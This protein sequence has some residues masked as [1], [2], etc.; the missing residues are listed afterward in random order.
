MRV[1]ATQALRLLQEGAAAVDV[2]SAAEYAAGHLP[3]ALHLPLEDLEQ[4][5]T[6]LPDLSRPLVLYCTSGIRSARAAAVL[7]AGGWQHIYEL[8]ALR[9]WPYG[10]EHN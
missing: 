8:G 2:R 5:R 3:G 1:N 7:R 10:I 9:S 6:V 4:A